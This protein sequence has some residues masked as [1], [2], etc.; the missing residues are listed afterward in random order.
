MSDNIYF[1]G[2]FI[3]LNDLYSENRNELMLNLTVE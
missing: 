3:K 1:I 2:K